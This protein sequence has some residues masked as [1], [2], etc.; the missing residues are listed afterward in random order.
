M[1]NKEEENKE[2]KIILWEGWVDS[3]GN[4]VPEEDLSQAAYQ[5]YLV[6]QSQGCT[7]KQY[8]PGRVPGSG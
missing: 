4:R 2:E 5:F 3:D 8:L 1:E 7:R 6:D